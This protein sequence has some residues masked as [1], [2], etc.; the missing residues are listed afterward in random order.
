MD[1]G[2]FTVVI[3]WSLLFLFGG[4]NDAVLKSRYERR[5]SDLERQLQDS[6]N[7]TARI[8]A[9]NP[10]KELSKMQ[11]E[12]ERLRD[13]ESEYASMQTRYLELLAQV[14]SLKAENSKLR[15]GE[16]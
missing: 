4:C 14:E 10:F 12:V 6:E 8:R 11:Q 3:L 16:F 9:R 5:I 15:N 1:K 2:G 7:A 13:L